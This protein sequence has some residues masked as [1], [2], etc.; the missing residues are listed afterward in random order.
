[1]VAY[2]TRYNHNIIKPVIDLLRRHAGPG[3]TDHITTPPAANG[4]ITEALRNTAGSDQLD[5]ANR[6]YRVKII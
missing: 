3:A 1:M 6:A 4:A 2:A 5:V